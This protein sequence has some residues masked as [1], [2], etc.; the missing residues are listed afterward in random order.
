MGELL[1]APK[2]LSTYIDHEPD[3]NLKYWNGD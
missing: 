1:D 3:N 2:I